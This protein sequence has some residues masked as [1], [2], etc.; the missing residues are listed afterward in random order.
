MKE[1]YFS[2]E[3]Y[4]ERLKRTKSKMEEKG[5]DL[6]IVTDPAN[7]NYLTGFDG[8]SFYVHQCLIVALDREEP[9]WVGRGQDAN[10]AEITSYL[11]EENVIPYTDDYVQSLVKHPMDF[12]SDIIQRE[13]YGNKTI[14][15]EMNSY[16]FHAKCKEGLDS[17]L[18]NAK[19][20][21]ATNL[22]N[23]VKI[24]KSDKEIEYIRKAA[25]IVEKTM[26]TAYNSVEKGVR[27]NEAAANVYHAQIY[28]TE[29]FG[30]DY[31][32]I[33]PLMPSG[34][35]TS[36]PHLSWTD[37]KY[38]E[39]DTVILELAGCY[40]RY[41]CPLSRT[42]II[43]EAPQKVKDLANVVAE[44]LT[45]ALNSI[46]P[47]ITCEE[48]ERVWAKSISKSGF[49]KD[50]RIGYSMGLNFPTDWGEH[51]ASFRPRDNTVLESNM[52]FH[53][54]PGI[55][56]DDCG[57]DISE[58]FRVTESGIELFTNYPRKLLEK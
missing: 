20:K 41:H 42:M 30:G 51:I 58:S 25:I 10:A 12:V 6:L 24:I 37:E 11:N 21:D 7:M 13:S 40:R 31:T 47:G 3:E 34:V 8:W 5:L 50:S 28:G 32:S 23:W 48:V 2:V 44:G 39:G 43:G 46:K 29:E 33:V 36:T 52:T 56:L 26:E 35:R 45:D 54:I 57:V 27:Q 18:K 17:N 9:I 55:W 19:F 49:I 14:G 53:M 1:I 22:V 15:T 4:K 16:Y 38:N